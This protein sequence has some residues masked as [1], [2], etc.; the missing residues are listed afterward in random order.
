MCVCHTPTEPESIEKC[1]ESETVNENSVQA[2]LQEY[3]GVQGK[4][5]II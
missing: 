5:E 2:K 3:Q 1:A 4:I